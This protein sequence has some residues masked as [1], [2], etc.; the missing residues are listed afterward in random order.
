MQTAAAVPS[1]SSATAFAPSL[2][3][4][5]AASSERIAPYWDEEREEWVGNPTE[6][7]KFA[8]LKAL[9]DEAREEYDAGDYYR[10]SSLEELR[11]FIREIGNEARAEA[12][13]MRAAQY[14]NS[15]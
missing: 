12:H 3:N 5:R 14:A 7:E 15:L 8:A 10:F 4:F 11:E 2:A 1:V 6:E 13:A 9:I